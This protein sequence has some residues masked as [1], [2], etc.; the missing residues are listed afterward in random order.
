M[1]SCGVE[2]TNRIRMEAEKEPMESALLWAVES[3][4]TVIDV[5]DELRAAV[6]EI[7]ESLEK[8]EDPNYSV[9]DLSHAASKADD[10]LQVLYNLQQSLKESP[11]PPS[12][13]KKGSAVQ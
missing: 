7:K 10:L 12:T 13:P 8:K 9:G 11:I 1:E 6:V 3:A 4:E 5:I 2:F